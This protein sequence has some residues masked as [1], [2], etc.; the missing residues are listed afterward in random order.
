MRVS[1][2]ARSM[3]SSRPLMDTAWVMPRASRLSTWSFISDWRGEMTTVSAF[4]FS[5]ARSAG[6]WKVM[7]LPPPVGKTASSE[8]PSTA[9]VAARSWSGSPA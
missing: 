8:R 4:S 9:A 6:T 2:L 5:P 7:D 1:A 3:G